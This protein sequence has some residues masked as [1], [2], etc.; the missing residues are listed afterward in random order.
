MNLVRGYRD[1]RRPF[2][3]GKKKKKKNKRRRV[4]GAPS[5][6]QTKKVK[7]DQTDVECFYCRKQ[8]HW[9][10]NCSLYQVSLDPNRLRKVKQHGAAQGIYMINPYNFSIC[11]T[12]DWVLDI[13][14]PIHIC[15]LLQG[16]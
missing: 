7:V 11:D 10:R 3:K 15:N 5:L 6:S 8:G 1:H 16:L 13:D 9:K 2:R 4:Q 12:V 14:S